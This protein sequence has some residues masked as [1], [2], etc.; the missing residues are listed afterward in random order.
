M[1][2]NDKLSFFPLVDQPYTIYGPGDTVRGTANLTLDSPLL[3][4]YVL[5]SLLAACQVITPS[6]YPRCTKKHILHKQLQILSHNR[7]LD[8]SRQLLKGQHKWDFEFSLPKA[9]D[10]PPSFCYRDADGCVDVIYCIAMAVYRAEEASAS[11]NSTSTVAIQYSP[12]RVARIGPAPDCAVYL[13]QHFMVKLSDIGRWRMPTQCNNFSRLMHLIKN[14]REKEESLQL[15]LWLPRYAAFSEHIDLSVKLETEKEDPLR[16]IQARLKRVEYRLWALTR[17]GDRR[18]QRTERIQVQKNV[19][20][21]STIL[22]TNGFWTSL[23]RHAPFRVHPLRPGI[24]LDDLNF[25]SIS[26]SFGMHNVVREYELDVSLFVSVCNVVHRITFE[27][28]ELVL[29]PR[30]FY[31]DND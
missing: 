21:C 14:V 6:S 15:T 31:V 16:I 30:E 10:L 7:R 26:P 9:N 8:P 11:K 17:I 22:D 23:R 28:N 12:K 13:R 25:T 3:S 18:K 24:A 1:N 5:V 29:L 2:G 27:S 20:P 19:C 4:K